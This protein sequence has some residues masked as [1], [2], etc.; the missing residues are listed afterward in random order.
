M[1]RIN[2]LSNLARYR[3]VELNMST[4]LDQHSTP[5][6]RAGLVIDIDL[7]ESSTT[8]I[9]LSFTISFF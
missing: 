2:H 8:S 5:G 6:N 4:E 1:H 9:E 3:F 7:T